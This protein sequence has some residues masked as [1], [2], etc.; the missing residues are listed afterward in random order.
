MLE[1]FKINN[2]LLKKK[3]NNVL[4]CSAKIN[5]D[6]GVSIVSPELDNSG[7]YSSEEEIEDLKIG[8]KN[9]K[10]IFF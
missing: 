7:T 9:F 5:E 2:S 4:N 8:N 1:Q 3:T 10:N 6:I